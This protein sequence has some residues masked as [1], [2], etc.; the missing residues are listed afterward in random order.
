MQ[1][2]YMPQQ[3]YY[4][5]PDPTRQRL[6]QMEAAQM[7]PQYMPNYSQPMQ[8]QRPAPA[9]PRIMS[10]PVASE[11]EAMAVQ[12]DFTGALQV[13]VDQAHGMIYTKQLSPQ[14]GASVFE[15]YALVQPEQVPQPEPV[16]QSHDQYVNREEFLKLKKDFDALFEMM[17]GNKEVAKHE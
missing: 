7:Q 15:K 4:P 17:A 2:Q 3:P 1:N 8:M 10:I 14:T 6:A 16:P 11:Q 13:M 5:Q 12:T 9:Y